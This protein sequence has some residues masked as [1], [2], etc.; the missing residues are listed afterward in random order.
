[1]TGTP[2]VDVL[3]LGG[4]SGS[5]KTTVAHEIS[6]LLQARDVWHC[7]LEGD[8][9]DAAHP[10]AADDPD[11]RALTQ[12][13]VT[14]LW[15]NYRAIGHHRLIYVNTAVVLEP[16]LVLDALGGPCRV[17]VVAFTADNDTV[18]ARLSQRE[19]GG[20]MAHHVE[21]SRVMAAVIDRDAVPETLW[22]ATDRRTVRDVAQEV[23]DLTG[24]AAPPRLTL[25]EQHPCVVVGQARTVPR[26][27][28]HTSPLHP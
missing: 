22:V 9:V 26:R 28:E 1:M 20:G 15:R 23:L 8:N 4:R 27:Q 11:G 18:A 24:W 17:T 21:R 16:D 13:N 7:H 19:T 5:G 25:E 12:A 14:A 10:K 6:A 2:I 3:L